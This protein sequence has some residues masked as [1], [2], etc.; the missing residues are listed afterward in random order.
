MIQI[1]VF[2]LEVA[3]EKM[4]SGNIFMQRL[5]VAMFIA[6]MSNIC[7]SASKMAATKSSHRRQS[8]RKRAHT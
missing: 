2:G 4:Q 7:Q 8:Q 3:H 6:K 5:I 1:V